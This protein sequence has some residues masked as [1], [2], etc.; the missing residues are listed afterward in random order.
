MNALL[1]GRKDLSR[2]LYARPFRF[3][4]M[5]VA[6]SLAAVRLPA[7]CTPNQNPYVIPY[8]TEPVVMDGDLSEWSGLT[9]FSFKTLQPR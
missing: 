5:L 7:Q 6:C 2:L 8:L 4:W 3:G 9:S 1:F